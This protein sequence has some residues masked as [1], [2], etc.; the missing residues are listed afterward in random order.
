MKDAHLN[1]EAPRRLG[2]AGELFSPP[3]EQVRTLARL[4]ADPHWKHLLGLTPEM[5]A[6][7]ERALPVWVPA[8]DFVAPVLVPRVGNE[9]DFFHYLWGLVSWSTG[10]FPEADVR[11][12]LQFR[13]HEVVSTSYHRG[14]SAKEGSRDV[15]LKWEWIDFAAGRGKS[16]P[17]ARPRPTDP[18]WG[19][20]MCD[21]NLLAAAIVH[22]RWARSMDGD[23]VPFVFLSDYRLISDLRALVVGLAHEKARPGGRARL[24]LT[25]QDAVGDPGWAFPR[26]RS[27][28]PRG[29]R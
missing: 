3:S 5:F 12:E 1:I 15:S 14:F 21:A 18:E 22:P 25:A 27:H 7:A 13:L 6:R 10:S 2:A 4:C 24:Y 23:R 20:Q 19:D 16:L 28:P 9:V 11:S 17:E 29:S 8:N 26:Y